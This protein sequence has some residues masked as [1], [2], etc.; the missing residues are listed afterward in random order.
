ME[1]QADRPNK[2]SLAHH[3]KHPFQTQGQAS[4]SKGFLSIHVLTLAHGQQRV[5]DAYTLNSMQRFCH[6]LDIQ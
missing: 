6:S 1:D 5:R 3:Q 4:G 2:L